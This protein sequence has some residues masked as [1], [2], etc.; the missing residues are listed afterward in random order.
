[1]DDDRGTLNFITD[2][3]RARAVAEATVG[4]V[5]SLAHLLTPVPL[6]GGANTAG[7]PTVTQIMEYNPP[8][9]DAF[10]DTLVIRVHDLHSTHVDS[11]AHIVSDGMVYPGIPADEA[12]GR[13]SVR[14]GGS[15]P[16][17]TGVTT[18][19]VLLDLAP[20]GALP[21]GHPITAADLDEA[22][23]RDGVQVDSGDALVVR[24]GWTVAENPSESLPYMT[25]SAVTWMAEREI[26]IYAGD[27]CDHPPVE[28]V[29]GC[30]MHVHA[31]NR[32]GMPLIDAAKVDELAAV[33][34]E[35][36]RWSFL[37]VLGAIAVTGATGLPVT[38]L[39]IF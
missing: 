32:L 20:D 13:G 7:P 12:V 22:A 23:R 2:D 5:V 6:A 38:P 27:V 34:A 24:G 31:L 39:A 4:R 8:Q 33:C 37:F 11:L 10:T 21:D 28:S 35:L 26:S 30:I 3:V 15:A 17:A 1:M 18:R 25:L 16:F 14:R 19:G 9:M 36:G 29:S